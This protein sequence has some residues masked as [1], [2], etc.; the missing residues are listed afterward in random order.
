M[1]AY[2]DY[3]QTLLKEVETKEAK[4]IEACAS[5]LTNT[6]LNKQ[7]I[8][9]FGASHAG[10]I[11][12]ELYYRAGGLMLFNPIFGRELM[13]DT[14][15]IL[16]TSHMEQLP[17]YGLLLAKKTPFKANDVLIIHSVSGRNPVSIDLA[18][19]AKEKGVKIVALTNV[20][21]SKSVTSRHPSGKNLYE[22][23]DIVLD[24]HGDVGDA[25]I[26]I[27]GLTQKVAPTSTV[28]GATI[29][30]EIVVL[31][32]KQLKQSGMAYPP[33]FYS[34]NLD[35]GSERNKELMAHYKDSIHY[36]FED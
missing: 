4:N 7:A 1:F 10:I 15:P 12:E 11:S 31:V 33:I 19:A 16:M 36:R 25:C 24:N 9:T 34:A 8:F 5:L 23:A 2:F 27:E 22:L 17:G 18:I 21:Y 35:G 26:Q 14:Q 32:T 6:I 13:L 3:I 28:I 29:M 20:T 30:N